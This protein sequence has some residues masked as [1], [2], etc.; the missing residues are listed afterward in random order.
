MLE[1]E[2]SRIGL[3]VSTASYFEREIACNLEEIMVEELVRNKKHKK[4]SHQPASGVG[5]LQIT[6]ILMFLDLIGEFL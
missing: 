4:D 5:R 1:A 2:T 6:P 3:A